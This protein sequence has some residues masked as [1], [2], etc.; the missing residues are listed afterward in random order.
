MVEKAVRKVTLHW[1]HT[2]DLHGCM[3]MYDDLKRCRTIGGA[4]AVYGHVESLRAKYPDSVIC[5]DGGDCLQGQP[6]S[7]YYNYIDTEE[8]IVCSMMNEI[9]YDA[10]TIG[11]HDIET[12]HKIYDPW[13]ASCNHPVLAANM[14]DNKTGTS[15]LPPY[16]VIE[17]CGIK[18]AVLGMVTPTIDNWLPAS[19]W[20]GVHFQDMVEC[21]RQWVPVIQAKENPHL[22]VGLFHSGLEGGIESYHGQENCTKLIAESV[23]GFDLIFYGHDH[24]HAINTVVCKDG[25]SVVLAAP[26][27][28]GVRLVEAKIMLTLNDGKVVNKKIHAS[29]PPIDGSVHPSAIL[30][31]M[32][33]DSMRQDALEWLDEEIGCLSEDLCEK[34]AYFGTCP[35][36]GLIHRLQLTHTGADISFAA[37]LSFDSFIEKGPMTVRDMFKLYRYENYLYTLKFTGKEIRNILE[38]SYDRWTNTMQSPDDHIMRII[39]IQNRGYKI[40]FE[41]LAFNFISAAGIR[42]TVDVTK[43]FGQKVCISGM[44]DGR[45]FEEEAS[46]TVAV[47]SYHGSG[48]G[49]IL[50]KGAG[51]DKA[52][53]CSRIIEETTD[54]LRSIFIK[55]IRQSGN[56][57]LTPCSDWHFEP[58]NWTDSA[59]IRDKMLLFNH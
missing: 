16:A 6:V 34:D 58:S 52:E 41:H 45:P 46:Y 4:S 17:R 40:G 10:A 25:K 39:P 22:L 50:P 43:P 37:P 18:I 35:F 29:T 31:E 56:I 51:I 30:L 15:Y 9:G 24:K 38:L 32:E 54:D 28:N 57:D 47:N 33:Y 3:F 12:G 2:S 11:N 14:I 7:Y 23:P 42:Y 49:E 21:A 13:L 20:S 59:I 26:S 1:V 48:G 5:T 44:F 55:N 53:L 19:L 27:N 36:I 8:N